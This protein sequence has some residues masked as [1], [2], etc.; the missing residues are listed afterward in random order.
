MMGECRSSVFQIKS[1]PTPLASA[2]GCGVA[3][4]GCCNIIANRGDT[5]LLS[6][7]LTRAMLT[8]GMSNHGLGPVMTEDGLRFGHNGADEGFQTQQPRGNVRGAHR[9]GQWKD[10][11]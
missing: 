8:P 9:R 3:P 7:K 6:P 1:D 11:G 2:P 5:R 4:H 10:G